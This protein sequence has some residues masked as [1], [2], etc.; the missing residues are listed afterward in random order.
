MYFK[1]W[2]DFILVKEETNTTVNSQQGSQGNDSSQGNANNGSQGSVTDNDSQGNATPKED[3]SKM[4]DGKLQEY[5]NKWNSAYSQDFKFTNNLP[6]SVKAENTIDELLVNIPEEYKIK[7]REGIVKLVE[8]FENKKVADAFGGKELLIIGYTSTTASE[9]YNQ[10]LSERRAKIVAN[11]IRS[12]IKQ[13][14]LTLNVKFKEEGMG[15]NPAGLIITNDQDLDPIKLGSNAPALD[16]KTLEL[17]NTSKEER[18]KLNRR[19]KITLPEF[20][21]NETPIKPDVIKPTEETKEEV[22]DKPELPQPESIQFNLNSFILTKESQTVLVTF[23]NEL[24]KWNDSNKE[25]DKKIKNIF[26]SSHVMRKEEENNDRKA[27]D[28]KIK[29]DFLT[30][31][32]LNRAKLVKDFIIKRLGENNG[33]QFYV[34]PVAFKMGNEEK[35]VVINFEKGEHMKKAEQV[36]KDLMNQYGINFGN[37]GV[38]TPTYDDNKSLIERTFYNIKQ[39]MDANKSTQ[40]IP[41]ELFYNTLDG[42]YG[43]EF[44]KNQ[45]ASFIEEFK[46]LIK[47][48]KG[49]V[50]DINEYMQKWVY[51][52]E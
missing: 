9:S 8:A 7:V 25:D 41:I 14:N 5:L 22:V 10:A 46:N 13:K 24:K 34:Y 12:V 44:Y 32:S 27:K 35:K 2:K 15:K 28:E 16:P 50:D 17:L 4:S 47:K 43:L 31:L 33:V 26:I 42:Y 3:V 51:D 19:V 11:A 48:K 36:S 29:D 49:N 39:T 21:F 30:K 1:K 6:K 20:K 23:C 40:W 45:R 18:Q 38:D 37:F 52:P